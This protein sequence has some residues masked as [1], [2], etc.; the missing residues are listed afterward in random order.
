MAP[1]PPGERGARKAITVPALDVP[2]VAVSIW[3][4][5]PGERV[6][7]GDRLVELLVG[8]ATFDVTAECSGRLV[9]QAALPDESAACGEVLGY[10]DTTE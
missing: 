7:E 5:K 2:S 10:L 8:S 6:Y 9:E 1:L 4:V 3:Y